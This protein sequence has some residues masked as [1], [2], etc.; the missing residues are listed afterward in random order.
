MPHSIQLAMNP[1][2]FLQKRGIQ[3]GPRRREPSAPFTWPLRASGGV[4][5]HVLAAHDGERLGIDLGY[6]ISPRG[7]AL[8]PVYAVNDGEVACAIESPTGCAISLDHSGT[9]STHYTGLTT[10]AVTRCLPKLKRRQYVRVGR[11]IGYSTQPRSGFE[12]WKWTDDRGFVAVDPRPYLA[13][14]TNAPSSNIAT[15]KEAA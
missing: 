11:V 15:A 5:P 10:L 4:A 3:L 1:P 6:P 2:R 7:H 12:L 14:W 13:L 8:V 9:W